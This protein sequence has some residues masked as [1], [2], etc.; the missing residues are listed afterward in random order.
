MTVPAS[1]GRKRRPRILVTRAEEV[2]G[3]RWDDYADRLG[4]A[5]ADCEAL[6]LDDWRPGTRI[7]GFDGLLISAGL[8]VDPACYGETPSSYVTATNAARDEF[9]TALL[10][11]ALERDLPVLAIC[12]GHQ[13]FN[14][15]HG[16]SLLQ[17]IAE[18]EPH[19][20]RSGE[21]GAIDSG[22]HEVTLAEGSLLAGLFGERSLNVNSR[23]HQAV[24]PDRLAPGL[25]V[26]ATTADGIVEA[27]ERP[28]RRWVVS[29]QWHPER[30]EIADQQ[31]PLFEAF[32]TACAETAAPD[33][34]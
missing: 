20:A 16:G 13:L 2:I 10:Q 27:L 32:V 12:R 28:D 24:T 25:R 30:E 9:E 17:H 23:H 19:R 34:G 22:W 5:G 26:A 11:D 4:E 8:D 33:A 21:D 31:R 6:D 18:R 7:E 15:A 29:V 3:E 1:A 14:V